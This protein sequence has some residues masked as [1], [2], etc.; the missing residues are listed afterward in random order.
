MRV[1]ALKIL[2]RPQDSQLPEL[3]ADALNLNKGNSQGLKNMLSILG[4]NWKSAFFASMTIKIIAALA[5]W[6][7]MILQGIQESS[8]KPYTAHKRW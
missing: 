6:R 1:S 7:Q 8:L 2:W 5:R 3:Q 4:C